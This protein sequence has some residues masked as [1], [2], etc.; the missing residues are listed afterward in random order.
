MSHGKSFVVWNGVCTSALTYHIKERIQQGTVT[1]PQL[2]DIY[3][4][5]VLNLFNLNSCNR[6]HFSAYADDLVIYVAAKKIQEIK[7]Q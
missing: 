5:A 6:T 1:A 4:S 3:N 2:F 7:T